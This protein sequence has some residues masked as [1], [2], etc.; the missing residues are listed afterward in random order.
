MLNILTFL[1]GIMSFR[2]ESKV[3]VVKDS[4]A[5]DL[6]EQFNQ[7]DFYIFD[8]LDSLG[9]NLKLL[10]ISEEVKIHELM[11]FIDILH[12]SARVPCIYLINR[13]NGEGKQTKDIEIC[14]YAIFSNFKLAGF[15]GTDISRGVNLISNTVE[16]SIV[17]P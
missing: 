16:S 10:S 4:T 2:I 8:K 14:G 17:V 7:S 1:H 9:Q 11:R 15:I 12:A 6:I 5:K 13:D 3:Y